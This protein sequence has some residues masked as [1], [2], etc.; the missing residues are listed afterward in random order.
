[1]HFILT[2]D[3]AGELRP[4][5]RAGA[6]AGR[7]RRG[8]LA[9]QHFQVYGPHFGSRVDAELVGQPG[10]QR[11]VGGERVRLPPGS[12]QR[13]HQQPGELLVQRVLR[14]QRLKLADAGGGPARV[15]LPRE[16][17]DRRVQPQLLK[18]AGERLGEVSGIRERRSAPQ[19]QGLGH[20]PLGDEPL[21][22]QRVHVVGRDR[23]P[24]PGRRLLHGR[25]PAQC[26]AG[27]RDQGLQRVRHFGG[28]RAV[29]DGLG[30][31]AGAHRLP[32]RQRQPGDQAAQPR[33]GDGHGAPPSSWTSSGPSIAT[34]TVLIVPAV[35]TLR[36]GTG[37]RLPQAQYCLALGPR[38]HSSPR[39]T[40]Y[41]L[42]PH[43]HGN[44]LGSTG[45]G[46][47]AVRRTV[48]LWHPPPPGT[49]GDSSAVVRHARSA[50][51]AGIS[52]S[53]WISWLG[54]ELA[55]LWPSRAANSPAAAPACQAG[56]VGHG[57]ALH[58]SAVKQAE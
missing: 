25:R 33:A 55:I 53:A 23:Q 47:E 51:L 4:E 40:G 43:D 13:P 49:D 22:A 1:M 16:E 48:P 29:P 8:Y 46:S 19:R 5:V 58:G 50:D 7:R 54:P 18:A 24:V 21:K 34:R 36:P 3:E 42:Q 27:P 39:G 12:G 11:L 17:G 10:P 38:G 56:D 28:E 31:R 2:A 20:G 41:A 52:P 14:D 44:D 35:A 32:A 30:K 26:P 37:L 45:G 9:A 57:R 15:E 6:A